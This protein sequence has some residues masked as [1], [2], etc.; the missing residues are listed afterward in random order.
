MRIR[1][2]GG[3]LAQ[4]C[5]MRSSDLASK[6]SARIKKFLVGLSAENPKNCP[7]QTGL[8]FA[9]GCNGISAFIWRLSGSRIAGAA[10]VAAI[11]IPRLKERGDPSHDHAAVT[12]FGLVGRNKQELL[13]IALRDK[14]LARDAKLLRKQIRH[15]SGAPVRQAQIVDVRP[16]RIGMPLNEK[17]LARVV[18]R[19]IPYDG[20]NRFQHNRLIRPN[21]RGAELEIDRVD[22]DAPH[23]CPEVYACQHLVQGIAAV[24]RFH[25]AGLK[26]GVDIVLGSN[27]EINDILLARD[28]DARRSERDDEGAERE[29]GTDGDGAVLKEHETP[30]IGQKTD[31][32]DRTAKAVNLNLDPHAVG[33]DDGRDR[34]AVGRPAYLRGST[35]ELE[36]DGFVVLNEGTAVNLNDGAVSR[37]F[38]NGLTLTVDRL[39]A[40]AH[41]R[42]HAL[43]LKPKALI[44]RGLAPLLSRHLLLLR[45][46]A[47]AIGLVRRPLRLSL[48]FGSG[49]LMA[50]NALLAAGLLLLRRG[51][52]LLLMK[53]LLSFM[54]LLLELLNLGLIGA[55]LGR[56]FLGF[57]LR[58]L[59][60]LVLLL[61]MPLLL[62]RSL[63]LLSLLLLKML[64]L[65]RLMLLLLSLLLLKMLLLLGPLLLKML[66]LLS[67]LLL[68]ML[69][70]L[71]LLLLKTLLLLSLLLLKMLLLLR[72]MLLLL[73]LPSSFF[74][75]LLG[76]LRLREDDFLL[77]PRLAGS[78]NEGGYGCQQ[79]RHDLHK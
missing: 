50:E 70:L 27:V 20:G 22:I 75:L 73:S 37:L 28:L 16:H 46:E 52:V 2:A 59:L 41:N 29:S 42:A 35:V 18:P 23:A 5:G 53:L 68:K 58:G 40:L 25:G 3:G 1:I 51:L 21:I 55:E 61:E 44:D 76:R 13:A 49:E 39:L 65:L 78:H 6:C 71:S 45:N 38:N 9:A 56:L 14:I 66:L 19:H 36:I 69:L 10:I 31:A 57:P 79:K 72:L 8:G 17:H 48:L 54:L 64:L 67:L 43:V 30:P 4:I 47:L 7:P 24:E 77:S 74:L 32:A 33:P 60:S 12:P 63:L 62:G 34:V 11:L 15:R 26:R